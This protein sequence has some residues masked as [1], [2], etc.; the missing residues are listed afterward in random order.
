MKKAMIIA[1]VVVGGFALFLGTTILILK[2]QGRLEGPS[3][4]AL[5]KTPVLGAF[6]PSPPPSEEA[7]EASTG[8]GS[9]RSEGGGTGG[10][11]GS[12]AGSAPGAETAEKEEE[13]L[14]VHLS[15]PTAFSTKE[16]K[17]LMDDTREN[18]ERLDREKAAI[19]L[20]RADLERLRRDLED[21]KAEIE[22]MMKDLAARKTEFDAARERFRKQVISIEADEDRNVRK[23]AEVYAAMKP[24]D[25]AKFF[26][27]MEI[28]QAVK[29]LARMEASKAAK[30]LP[31]ID[32]EK[33]QRITEM[34]VRFQDRKKTG[35]TP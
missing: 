1:G 13:A 20:E 34:L 11:G 4:A 24:E 25:A 10:A 18:R 31:F 3:L 33:V 29:I 30:V 15:T 9:E 12:H 2:V 23:L 7:G 6:L 19:E 35:K 16:L 28:E 32:T 17:D 5:K 22:K 14:P 27:D 26:K 21:R 8:A